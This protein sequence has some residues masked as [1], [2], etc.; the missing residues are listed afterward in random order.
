MVAGHLPQHFLLGFADQISKRHIVPT[1]A[2]HLLELISG[3]RERILA[4]IERNPSVFDKQLEHQMGIL[5]IAPIRELCPTE[6]TS[7]WPKA[8]LVDGADECSAGEGRE[9]KTDDER[10]ESKEANHREV[11]SALVKLAD[12]SIFSF[13]IVINR[14]VL[15]LSSARNI[16]TCPRVLR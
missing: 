8:I 1:L 4:S 16:R 5:L 11:L 6:N 14:R 13:R 9:Y 10:Q 15:L 2:F 3:L 7:E 12:D